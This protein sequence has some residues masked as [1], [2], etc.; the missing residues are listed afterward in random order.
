MATGLDERVSKSAMTRDRASVVLGCWVAA[1]RSVEWSCKGALCIVSV[2]HT[3][4]CQC[5]AQMSWLSANSLPSQRPTVSVDAVRNKDGEGRQKSF[6]RCSPLKWEITGLLETAEFEGTSAIIRIC[7]SLDGRCVSLVG[8]IHPP[9]LALNQAMWGL[10]PQV[11]SSCLGHMYS[12]GR[13]RYEPV[14]AVPGH[15]IQGACRRLSRPSGIN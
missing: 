1:K 15:F 7:F 3:Y 4:L 2:V 14:L 6:R 5:D 8:E 9:S 13:L 11:G 10:P 12:R